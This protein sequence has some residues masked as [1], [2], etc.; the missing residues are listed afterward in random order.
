MTAN[1]R[2]ARIGPPRAGRPRL[3]PARRARAKA[4][5][6]AVLGGLA[7]LAFGLVLL[8]KPPVV[9][10]ASPAAPWRSDAGAPRLRARPV[11]SVSSVIAPAR[12]V[13]VASG[14]DREE[15]AP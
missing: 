8:V 3:T 2:H 7:G 13:E 14:Q 4:L 12:G 15:A 9:D 10:G 6:A 11:A 1:H 5:G